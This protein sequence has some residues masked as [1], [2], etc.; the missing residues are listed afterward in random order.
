MTTRVMY[1]DLYVCTDESGNLYING[2]IA[3]ANELDYLKQ[4]NVQSDVIDLNNK[5]ASSYNEMVSGDE[6]LAEL[7]TKMRSGLQVSVGEALATAEATTPDE[8]TDNASAEEP[9]QITVTLKKVQKDYLK[10]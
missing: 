7:L 3:D 4:V 10:E 6:K 2:D 5:V 8:N 9:D 1:L